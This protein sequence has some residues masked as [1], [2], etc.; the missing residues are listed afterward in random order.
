M[1]SGVRI[2]KN[3]KQGVPEQLES[4]IDRS[5]L[6]YVLG[7]LAQICFEKSEHI[8]G[9]WQDDLLAEFWQVAGDEL[10]KLADHLETI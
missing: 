1:V 3:W 4:I 2:D 7:T 6:N 10:D 9:N 8:T 5:S